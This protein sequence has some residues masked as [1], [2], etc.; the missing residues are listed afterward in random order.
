MCPQKMQTSRLWRTASEQ[1]TF[2]RLNQGGRFQEQIDSQLN[3][4][5]QI[6]M[7]HP[8]FPF[9]H[10]VATIGLTQQDDI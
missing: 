4:T 10:M 5:Y 8:P 3:K 2:Y 1:A 9:T 7:Y 6:D